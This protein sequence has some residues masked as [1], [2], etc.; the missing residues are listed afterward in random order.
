M[1]NMVILEYL[2]MFNPNQTWGHLYEFEKSLAEFFNSKGMEATV[3]KTVDGVQGRRML[4]ISKKEVTTLP[5][6]PTP[7][8]R[9]KGL[10][11]YIKSVGEQKMK[12]PFTRKFSAK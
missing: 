6:T 2:F 1:K 7:A 5:T 4:V 12:L 3:V 10:K 8:G 9:P 11:A